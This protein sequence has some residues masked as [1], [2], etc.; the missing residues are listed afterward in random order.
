M[1][2]HFTWIS[3]FL[4]WG[5]ILCWYFFLYSYNI[6]QRTRTT[7]STSSPNRL[8]LHPY[9]GLLR[10]SFFSFHFCHISLTLSSDV[11]FF[12]MDDH[13]IQEMKYSGTDVRDTPMW[14]REQEKSK[15][16]TQVG[17]SARVDANQ[18][19]QRAAAQEE[20]ILLFVCHK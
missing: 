18:A 6:L 10:C 9:T 2:S 13:I 17:Y 15:Q 5:S 7:S 14:L 1:I 20:E 19:S 4:I 8:D 16:L 11:R 3:H 12:P